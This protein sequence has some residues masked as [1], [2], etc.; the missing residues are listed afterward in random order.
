VIRTSSAHLPV[1]RGLSRPTAHT[2]SAFGDRDRVASQT[3]GNIN[4]PWQP[5]SRPQI[6]FSPRRHGAERPS[7]NSIGLGGEEVILEKPPVREFKSGARI[8][9]RANRSLA[10]WFEVTA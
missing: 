8:H 6:P 10:F 5:G 7:R 4:A 1:G 3:I 9:L 2:S